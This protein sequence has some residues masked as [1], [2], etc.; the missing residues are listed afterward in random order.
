MSA[1]MPSLQCILA[2]SCSTKNWR[3]HFSRSSPR[4]QYLIPRN[5]CSSVFASP[6][7]MLIVHTCFQLSTPG[8]DG[9]ADIW[10]RKTAVERRI[11]TSFQFSV[12]VH[13]SGF[14]VSSG[15]CEFAIENLWSH[16]YLT[17]RVCFSSSVDMHSESL[18][19]N[20]TLI[21]H[22]FWVILMP[23]SPPM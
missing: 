15:Y 4:Y 16:V 14:A 13:S 9:Q 12:M 18:V 6:Q 2:R 20:N 23:C 21:V 10:A 19:L 3:K 8:F 11:K 17:V 22:I 5:C 1:E 7:A